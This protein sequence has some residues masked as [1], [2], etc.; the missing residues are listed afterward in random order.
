MD[1]TM[2]NELQH[3]IRAF[4]KRPAFTA[5][6]VLTLALGIGA[7]A[8]IFTLVN[9]FLIK[10][11]P[12]PE[13][14]RLISVSD[15]QPPDAVTPASFPEFEDWRN[16]NQ[17]FESLT[18]WFPRAMNLTG[19]AEPQ[20]IRV[21]QVAR[22]YFSTLGIDAMLGRTF[23]PDEHKPGAP[24]VAVIG[25]ALWRTEF[26]S[27]M[28]VTGKTLTVGGEPY[29]VVG[30]LPSEPLSVGTRANA[31]L[32]VPLER[33]LLWSSRGTHFLAVVG[34]LK[35]GVSI[36]QARS[37]LAVLTKQLGD[38]NK[39]DHGIRI[40]ALQEQMFGNLR[41]TLVILLVAAGFLLLIAAVNVANLLLARSSSRAREFAI[42]VAIGASRW[43][44]IRQT[45]IESVVLATAGGAAGLGL[46]L[47][48]SKL[49]QV[50]WPAGVLKPQTFQPDWR[51]LLFLAVISF[52]TALLFGIAPAIQA[53]M[54]ALHEA[55]KGGWGHP[56]S[57][58]RGRTR[59]VLVVS[60]IAVACVLL[61]GAGLLLKSFARLM[62]VDPGFHAENV[63]T[64]SVTLPAA[65]YK[66]DAQRQAF[67]DAALGRLRA[68]P[69]TL[70]AGAILN[71]PLSEGGM[72]GSVEIIGRTFPKDREPVTEKIIVT[73]EYF[74]A[75]GMR[76]L[77]GRWFTGQDGTKG[78]AAVIINE[79][80]ARQY[81]PHEDPIGK[82]MKIQLGISDVQEIVGVVADVKLDDLSAVPGNQ[83]YLPYKDSPSDAMT[84]V[85]RTAADPLQIIPAV[86]RAI[87]EIDSEQPIADVKTMQHVV[88]DSLGSR[89]ISTGVVGAFAFFALLLASVGVYGVVSYWVSQ[90]TREIGIRNAIGARR[91]DIF[92]LVLSRGMLLVGGG[93]VAGLAASFILTRYLASLLFGV[94]THDWMTMTAVPVVLA[95]I[96]FL[97]CCIPA[98]R[99]SRIDPMVA[100]R[101]E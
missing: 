18:A 79:A 71:L 17:V 63:L 40:K 76:L 37:S 100:L 67:F 66:E 57:G 24:A 29:V 6:V 70:A 1:L 55:L 77:R 91:W 98:R 35:P 83:T 95:V 93:V 51:V 53:S 19:S 61:I 20:R 89:R 82:Q 48:M 42:R 23:A 50:F 94:S 9:A 13:A 21:V 84:L 33:D 12:F 101:F 54:V 46:S 39:T 28:N 65:K 32:W 25:S 16:T 87:R 44:L 45:L 73:P 3:A 75:I 69:G 90:R 38:K 4:L 14:G 22:G 64:M 31:D 56:S 15:F 11:L 34:R 88:S 27:A 85:V 97:A 62:A 30:V 86:R 2:F 99:A 41:P 26:G 58:A 49:L 96:A 5:I 68:M 43:R 80:M 7:N 10:P 8:T 81:W 72:N 52:L 92:E 47:A 74:Q 78:H 59:N 60:E 36:E